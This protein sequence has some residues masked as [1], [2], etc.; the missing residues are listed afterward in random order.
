MIVINKIEVKIEKQAA[1]DFERLP[2]YLKKECASH[3]DKLRYIGFKYGKELGDKHGMDLTGYYKI[4][5]NQAKH[6]IIYRK[7]D[8]NQIEII[9]I[10]AIGE[11]KDF[12]VYKEAFSRVNTEEQ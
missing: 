10:V 4:S 5:F 9:Y 2:V 3:I 12:N 8:D 7:N 11:R 1:I 6:R